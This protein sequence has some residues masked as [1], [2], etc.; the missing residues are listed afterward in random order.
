MTV[1]DERKRVCLKGQTLIQ[2]KLSVSEGYFSVSLEKALFSAVSLDYLYFWFRL[3]GSI[4]QGMAE[5]F[6]TGVLLHGRMHTPYRG[7]R[8]NQ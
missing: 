6:A 8:Q 4:S 7:K 3:V 2:N 5:I 1:L